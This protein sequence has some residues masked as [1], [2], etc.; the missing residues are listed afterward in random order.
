MSGE[1]SHSN[2]IKSSLKTKTNEIYLFNYL[3]SK[4]LIEDYSHIQQTS[5]SLRASIIDWLLIIKKSLK[6]STNTFFYG[7]TLF[8]TFLSKVTTELDKDQV[9]LYAAVC[10]FISKKYN[11]VV[12]ISPSFLS[13]SILKNKYTLI[14]INKAETEIMKQLKFKLYFDTSQNF[15]EVFINTITLPIDKSEFLEMNICIN[16]FSLHILELVFDFCPFALALVTFR[17]SIILFIEN[18]IIE[19]I[20]ANAIHSQMQTYLGEKYTA[21]YEE[22]NE[23]A[24]LLVETFHSKE[25]RLK[26]KEYF[27]WYFITFD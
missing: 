19:T 16:V 17:S 20:E 7:I 23:M 21:L 24:I 22:A 11:D 8:D 3:F 5:L 9:Q 10:Y 15:T 18:Q 4:H 13:K 27:Q 14:E 2:Q 25:Q 1:M 12:L 6:D 26:H